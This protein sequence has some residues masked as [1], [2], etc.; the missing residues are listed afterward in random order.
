MK[1]IVLLTLVLFS[2]A[3]CAQLIIGQTILGNAP[4][5]ANPAY[6][7]VSF[8][9]PSNAIAFG[10]QV[11]NVTSAQFDGTC[12]NT[13][14]Q[15][16][17]ITTGSTITG[18]STF[19]IGSGNTCT[20]NSTIVPLGTCTIAVQFTP[21]AVTGY[22]G[23]VTVTIT[24]ATGSP[25]SL[26]LSGTGVASGSGAP[27]GY[28][29]PT[30][31]AGSLG[32]TGYTTLSSS[33]L[34]PEGG[35]DSVDTNFLHCV[36]PWSSGCSSTSTYSGGFGGSQYSSWFTCAGSGANTTANGLWSGFSTSSSWRTNNDTNGVQIITL[37][38]KWVVLGSS[39]SAYGFFSVSLTSGNPS[40]TLS[41]LI[42][43]V[44]AAFQ[45]GSDG[46]TASRTKGTSNSDIDLYYTY[47]SQNNPGF[48]TINFA[49]GAPGT[50]ALLVSNLNALTPTVC[51]ITIGTNASNYGYIRTSPDNT[52]LGH[53]NVVAYITG[54]SSEYQNTWECLVF[55]QRSTG[56]VAWWDSKTDAC[57]S[58]TSP[59]WSGGWKSVS[60]GCTGQAVG[61]MHGSEG[62]S[63][64]G[65]YI[66]IDDQEGAN[67][68]LLFFNISTQT[69]T[70]VTATGVVQNGHGAFVETS[71]CVLATG[72]TPTVG[73]INC[74][75][76]GSPSTINFTAGRLGT[77]SSG[78]A[79]QTDQHNSGND[80]AANGSSGTMYSLSYCASLG[81]PT[82][83]AGTSNY[84]PTGIGQ[85]E[86]LMITP[87]PASGT[88]TPT[89][90]RFAHSMNDGIDCAT[91][92]C[93]T[94]GTLSA[95]GTL[96]AFMSNWG[97][98]LGNDNGGSGNCRSVVIFE[99][100][101]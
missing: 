69:G 71:Y 36:P 42:S 30:A 87:P 80:I 33:N 10:N 79:V 89:N 82:G 21:V 45:Q 44:N 73:A 59:A 84:Q 92:W 7:C 96:G 35:G 24:G 58:T 13:G 99:S 85:Q 2:R 4:V 32:Y 90:Y 77:A 16:L 49:S 98:T 25:Q 18:S 56:A 97:C 95:D 47:G 78:G 70:C 9:S 64:D 3:A 14:N 46:P 51:G 20:T 74:T 75:P 29:A 37:D 93:H 100:L 28:T 8:Q 27:T 48:G 12:T 23:T 26:S 54:T 65:Q 41:E 52:A 91:F 39:S 34:P 62:F 94:G 15:I 76:E 101:F 60:S 5:A 61:T 57:G 19:T 6:S 11:E 31:V 83:C 38:D 72:S 67:Q 22:S 88:W 81:A 63:V 86:L 68:C 50:T 55:L 40:C 1:N 53:D 66:G 43:P 17:T